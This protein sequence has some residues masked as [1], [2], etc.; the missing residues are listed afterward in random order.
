MY[1]NDKRTCGAFRSHCKYANDPNVLVAVLITGAPCLQDS[2]ESQ[3]LLHIQ[4]RLNDSSVLNIIA[5]MLFPLNRG[6]NYWVELLQK[7]QTPGKISL[8]FSSSPEYDLWTWSLTILHVTN[9]VESFTWNTKSF[10]LGM[11]FP[12]GQPVWDWQ[13]GTPHSMHLNSQDH[14]KKLWWEK[15]LSS[16]RQILDFLNIIRQPVLTKWFEQFQNTLLDKYMEKKL[17]R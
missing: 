17:C 11:M 10:H 16:Q 4:Q 7:Y 5:R 2:P 3:Q 15:G 6:L 13:K 8:V 9:V 12:K 14:K 1:K